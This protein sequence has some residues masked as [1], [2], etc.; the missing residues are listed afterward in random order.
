MGVWAGL[1]WVAREG[2]GAGVQQRLIRLILGSPGRSAVRATSLLRQFIG[3]ATAVVTRF[4]PAWA[5]RGGLGQA[6]GVW[7]LVLFWLAPTAL[8]VAA[9][10]HRCAVRF[11]GVSMFSPHRPVPLGQQ[12]HG[13]PPLPGWTTGLGVAAGSV[14]EVS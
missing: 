14:R 3:S 8:L 9:V 1:K 12:A 4:G 11:K 7:L 2:T 5:R 13:M 6:V 10:V